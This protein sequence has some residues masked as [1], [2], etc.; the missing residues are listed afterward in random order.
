MTSFT[1][2]HQTMNLSR[3]LIELLII[4]VNHLGCWAVWPL[5]KRLNYSHIR[6]D[7]GVCNGWDLQALVKSNTDNSGL[8][9]NLTGCLCQVPVH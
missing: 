4:L 5:S 3:P 6:Q 8:V 1:P 7:P 9:Q 2:I